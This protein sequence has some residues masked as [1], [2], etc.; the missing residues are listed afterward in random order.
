MPSALLG[1]LTGL[2]MTRGRVVWF[3]CSGWGPFAVVQ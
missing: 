2:C 1:E 3:V